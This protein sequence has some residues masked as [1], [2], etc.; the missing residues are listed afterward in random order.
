MCLARKRNEDEDAANKLYTLVTH[1]PV[2]S[3]KG[4]NGYKLQYCNV[5][6][7]VNLIFY[8]ILDVEWYILN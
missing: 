4:N 5:I 6:F 2:E 7:L 3:F 8:E 1:V